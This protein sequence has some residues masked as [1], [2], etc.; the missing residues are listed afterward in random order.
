[1]YTRYFYTVIKLGL[2]LST[3]ACCPYTTTTR[4]RGFFRAKPPGVRRGGASP[5]GANRTARKTPTTRCRAMDYWVGYLTAA[6]TSIV[7][8]ISTTVATLPP[9]MA[10]L[11]TT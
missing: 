4:C 2:F 10:T 5:E 11:N 7:A 9:T 1:M 3:R 6:A 8:A